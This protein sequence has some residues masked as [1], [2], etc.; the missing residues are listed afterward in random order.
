MADRK[1]HLIVVG[2]LAVDEI[3][4]LLP[5]R[6]PTSTVVGSAHWEATRALDAPFY[7]LCGAGLDLK[8]LYA[9]LDSEN[10]QLYGLGFWNENDS[11][12]IENLATARDEPGAAGRGVLPTLVPTSNSLKLANLAGA[13]GETI[14]VLRFYDALRHEEEPHFR[15]D[16]LSTDPPQ[17]ERS[18]F[19]ELIKNNQL[20]PRNARVVIV[21]HD[22]GQYAVTDNLIGLL[23]S[24]YPTATWFVR[25]KQWN[26]ASWI[27]SLRKQLRLLLIGPENLALVRPWDQWLIN[28]RITRQARRFI[29][30]HLEG[31]ITAR[32]RRRAISTATTFVMLSEAHE[33]ISL[34][35]QKDA[36]YVYATELNPEARFRLNWTSVIFSHFIRGAL[37]Q[38]LTSSTLPECVNGAASAAAAKSKHA[39]VL[40]GSSPPL[41]KWQTEE[42]DWEEWFEHNGVM[43]RGEQGLQL[44]VWR[45]YTARSKYIAVIH[46][47]REEINRI[48]ALLRQFGRT[49]EPER[50]L[51]I[52]LSADPG[53]GKSA[54]ARA[55]AE[56]FNFKLVKRDIS[57]MVRREDLTDLFDAVASAQAEAEQNQHVLVFVDEINAQLG[58]SNV[59]GAFLSPL[60]EGVFVRQSGSFKL[61]PCVWI[62]AGT[63]MNA[64]PEAT[65]TGNRKSGRI[66]RANVPKL[67]KWPDFESRITYKANLDFASLRA[68]SAKTAYAKHL[69]TDAVT[70]HVCIGAMMIRQRFPESVELSAAVIDRIKKFRPS[71][72]LRQIRSYINGLECRGRVVVDP[73]NVGRNSRALA[74]ERH[75]RLVF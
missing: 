5:R 11:K 40:L 14:R 58:G 37:E 26:T 68:A 31:P 25:S 22:L 44:E 7:D 61:R 70:E 9:L 20:P 41:Q 72:G 71:A 42:Q 2:D 28:G 24:S 32:K 43:D 54:L 19:T 45:A 29:R 52:L 33:V 74:N 34:S 64:Q 65:R 48:A 51:S 55:L 27:P 75:I 57:Q 36:W 73:N 50:P 6:S 39:A 67:D 56:T 18:K 66:A 4:R 3:W 59:F 12:F 17:V 30:D 47:K 53:A 16:W 38:T 35:Y 13:G 15:I 63:G 46:Q 8:L 49:N 69:N 62:F 21:V 23:R 1:R 60:E 10:W